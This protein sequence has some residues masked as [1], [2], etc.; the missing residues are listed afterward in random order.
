MFK[1][2]IIDGVHQPAFVGDVCR[3]RIERAS[4][5]IIVYGRLDPKDPSDWT[6]ADDDNQLTVHRGNCFLGV[7]RYY[8]FT[9]ELDTVLVWLENNLQFKKERKHAE[10]KADVLSRF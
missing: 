2:V 7:D 3:E 10:W 5:G 1:I 8:V 4:E 6:K 9:Q